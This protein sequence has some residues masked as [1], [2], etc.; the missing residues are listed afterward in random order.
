MEQLKF[1]LVERG[2]GDGGRPFS[3]TLSKASA[4]QNMDLLI[5]NKN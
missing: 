2:K 1:I 4:H 5:D 3:N